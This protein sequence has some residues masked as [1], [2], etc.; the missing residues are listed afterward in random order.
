MRL[1]GGEIKTACASFSG[2]GAKVGRDGEIAAGDV[3]ERCSGELRVPPG[4]GSRIVNRE[5]VLGKRENAG[6]FVGC[7]DVARR[8]LRSLSLVCISCSYRHH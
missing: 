3:L 8:G 1:V 7:G 5:G 6:L 4:D 2:T